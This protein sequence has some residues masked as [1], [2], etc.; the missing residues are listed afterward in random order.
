VDP[1]RLMSQTATVT[2]VADTGAVDPYGNPTEVTT[3]A[4]S[5]CYLSF[6]PGSEVEGEAIQVQTPV[7]FLPPDAAIDGGDRITVDG[8]TYEVDGVPAVHFNPRL[9][10]TTHIQANLKRAG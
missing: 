6:V 1:T 8:I 5:K 3:V 9:R 10:R 7:L 4:T 2:H